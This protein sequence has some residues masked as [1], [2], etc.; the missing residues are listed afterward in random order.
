MMYRSNRISGC[1]DLQIRLFGCKNCSFY[2]I[3]AIFG[4]NF[5]YISSIFL[6]CAIELSLHN[7]TLFHVVECLAFRNQFSRDIFQIW[8][9]CC[10]Y[11]DTHLLK[12]LNN[13]LV[14][15]LSCVLSISGITRLYAQKSLNAPSSGFIQSAHTI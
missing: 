8:H 1:H 14:D 15:L 13:Q 12:F 3:F 5:E 11:G 6:L 4:Y 7:Y 9:A 10:K 2:P